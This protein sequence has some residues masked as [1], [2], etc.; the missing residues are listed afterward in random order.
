[1][2][3]KTLC[4]HCVFKIMDDTN[5]IGCHLDRLNKLPNHKDGLYQVVDTYCSTCRNVYWKSAQE[6]K[7]LLSLIDTVYE[8]VKTKF[9]VII[10]CA[11]DLTEDELV[12]S[13]DSVSLS[14]YKPDKVFISLSN[15]RNNKFLVSKLLRRLDSRYDFMLSFEK[16]QNLRIN[17]IIQKSKSTFLYFLALGESINNKL[18]EDINQS[19]NIDMKPK[20][21]FISNEAFV[22]PAFLY[23][24]FMYVDE[25]FKSIEQYVKSIT[26]DTAATTED[27][28]ADS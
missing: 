13:L 12:A 5:Q 20:L 25:P 11:D 26:E 2:I 24:H 3:N 15:N 18:M 8:E 28:S 19:I 10:V 6:G 21:T 7:N 14:S 9:D 22:C 23:S 17:A 4:E 27:N 16:E 1:M